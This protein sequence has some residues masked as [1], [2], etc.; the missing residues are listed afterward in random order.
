MLVTQDM[1][2]KL[3]LTEKSFKQQLGGERQKHLNLSKKL[4]EAEKQIQKLKEDIKV[5]H[6]ARQKR[7]P[8]RI[9]FSSHIQE[10][11][12]LVHRSHIYAHRLNPGTRGASSSRMSGATSLGSLS[13][14]A[15]DVKSAQEEDETYTISVK[16]LNGSNEDGTSNPVRCVIITSSPGQ[17]PP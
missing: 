11:E 2:R 7:N 6:S 3:T 13:R 14:L 12:K 5:S 10:K 9:K 15:E 1:R 4:A 8:Q 17:S 16:S